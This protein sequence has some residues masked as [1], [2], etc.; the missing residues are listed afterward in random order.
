MKKIF[1]V[2]LS[3]RRLAPLGPLC[4]GLVLAAACSSS[5][6]GTTR[7]DGGA[8]PDGGLPGNNLGQGL[9]GGVAEDGSPAPPQE[10]GVVIPPGSVTFTI[11]MTKG[12][13]RQFQPPATPQAVSP[14]V[15]GINGFGTYVK[16]ATQWGLI[17][18]GGDAFTSWNWASNYGNS[19]ADYCFWQGEETG[20]AS[21]AGAILQ[22]GDSL[23]NAQAKGEA[24]LTTIPI[25]EHVSSEVSNN[26]G[27]NNL[28]PQTASNCNGGTTTSTA[29]NSGNLDFVST[30]ANSTA[31][32]ANTASKGATFCTCPGPACG[33]GCTVVQTGPVYGDELAN[34]LHVN[35]AGTSAPP[36]FLMLDNEPNYWGS[37]HPELWPYTGTLPCETATVFYDDIVSRN[38]TFA[39]AIKKAWAGAKVVGPVV[40]Q[41]GIIYA[42][43]YA[44]DPHAGTEFSDYYLQQMAAASKTFGSPLIDVFDVHYY[45]DNSTDPSQC[46]QSPR[47][48]WDPGYTSLSASATDAIDFGWSGLNNYFDTSWYPRQVITRLLGKIAT[49]YPAGGTAAPGLSFSEYNSGCETV[50]AGGVAE[51]D[52]LG[53]FGR[54][55]VFAATAW[56]L[57]GSST[58]NYLV[59]AFDAYRNYDGKGTVVG[60]TA[61][62]AIT[63]NVEGTSVY[64]FAH[65][66]DATALDLVILNKATVTTTVS[67]AIEHAPSLGTVTAYNLVGGSAA[68]VAATGPAPSVS[69]GGGTCALG[70]TMPAMSVTT[71]VLR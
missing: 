26:T 3:H 41:D 69:C 38:T 52:N 46:V 15:Y 28:C 25:L 40:A 36:L 55:G 68:V 24:Y 18:Q 39:T 63:S 70:Y 37:T 13:A 42:H 67:I 44:S 12:P 1:R 30:D 32:V 31:F 10:G 17:R 6:N 4:L 54:E 59:A 27:I 20:G 64:A 11:D 14:Y 65:S 66:T 56:P 48:F 2:I 47:M 22:G 49:A 58:T 5:S 60:D 21:V 7:V 61:V 57:Q 23:P 34:F 8:T 71:L 35:Y 9:D 16:Q 29:V 19:G 33:S 51:A 53:I 62:S 50:I 43:S 45:N